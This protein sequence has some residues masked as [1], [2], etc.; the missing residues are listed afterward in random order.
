MLDPLG[1]SQVLPYLRLLAR[2]HGIVLV[3]F[4]KKARL[5]DRPALERIRAELQQCGIEWRPFTYHKWP[6]VPATC[7]DIMVGAVATLY[8]GWRCRAPI[9]HARS[10]LP[11]VMA[12]PA[13][14]LFGKK[15]IFDIRGFWVDCR[16]EQGAWSAESATYR[17]LKIL[18]RAAY[19]NADAIISLTRRAAAQI[20][21][22]DF[23][24]TPRPIVAVITTCVDLEKFTPPGMPQAP[25]PRPFVFG[26]VGSVGRL[27]MFEE[28]VECFLALRTMRPG[29]RLLIV[30]QNSHLEIEAILRERGVPQEE[31]QLVAAAYEEVPAWVRRMSAAVCFVLSTPSMAAATPTKIG[32]YLATGV[33][34]I[35]NTQPGDL[36]E[37]F[38]GSRIGVGVA[39]MTREAFDEA[40]PRLLRLAD[41][42]SARSRCRE[43]AKRLFSLDRGAAVY[44][45]LYR[46]LL[47]L[48]V[49]SDGN[50][51]TGQ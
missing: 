1:Q 45:A 14:W 15:L 8:Y 41:D 10:L 22:F 21:A 2:R 11:A 35:A 24:G 27:Y 5:S 20:R 48:A 29:A 37:L 50:L 33:P 25:S 12:L 9:I 31:Y 23:L 39:N 32:E 40:L 19:S 47:G 26:Y 13:K 18:E 42:P 7:F 4:E 36:E 17:T 46:R 44:D 3:S 49:S 43:V 30:N 38:S 6:S 28:A 16:L 34:V 51:P